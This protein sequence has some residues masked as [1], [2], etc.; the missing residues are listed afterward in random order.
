MGPVKTFSRV[1]GHRFLNLVYLTTVVG[2]M[3]LTRG[4]KNTQCVFLIRVV[5]LIGS[6]LVSGISSPNRGLRTKEF[7]LR[8]R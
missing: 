7:N 8:T 6:E 1:F 4:L 3:T 2:F 5:K